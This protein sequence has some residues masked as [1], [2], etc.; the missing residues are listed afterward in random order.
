MWN[1]LVLLKIGCAGFYSFATAEPSDSVRE[2]VIYSWMSLP[3][4][5]QRGVDCVHQLLT[6][7][8]D[9]FA[10]TANENRSDCIRLNIS[11]FSLQMRPLS[12]Q[13]YIIYKLSS[14]RWFLPESRMKSPLY[15]NERQVLINRSRHLALSNWD[16]IFS[17]CVQVQRFGKPSV[18]NCTLGNLTFMVYF[19]LLQ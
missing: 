6:E 14:W 17:T 11:N 13:K 9:W 5:L 1:V 3:K 19:S 12:T 10:C 2:K 7:I 16:A 18:T 4:T 8:Q 15:R